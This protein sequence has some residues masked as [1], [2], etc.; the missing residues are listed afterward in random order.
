MWLSHVAV[1]VVVVVVVVLA[2]VAFASCCCP[3]LVLSH[4]VVFVGLKDHTCFFVAFLPQ[5]R[6]QTLWK[7]ISKH[8]DW[9]PPERLLGPFRS[10]FGVTGV[11]RSWGV[12]GALV[13]LK[14]C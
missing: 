1:A 13:F 3:L 10:R 6:W 11:I 5:F 9:N 4:P 14:L 12:F 2:A 7:L 8:K